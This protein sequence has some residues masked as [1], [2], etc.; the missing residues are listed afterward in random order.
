MLTYLLNDAVGLVVNLLRQLLRVD[1]LLRVFR[2]RPL[3]REIS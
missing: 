2:L 3:E 1:A